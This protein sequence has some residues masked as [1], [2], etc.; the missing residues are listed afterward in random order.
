[1]PA[2]GVLGND[3]DPEGAGPDRERRQPAAH[4]TLSL[5]ANGGYT[6]TPTAN[7]S[8]ADSFTYRANSGSTPSN[9]ATVSLT[10]NAVNDPPVAG[11]DSGTTNEETA[12]VVAAPGV[13]GNDTDVDGATLTASVVVQPAHGTL[14]LNANGSYTLH[15]DGELQRRGQLHLPGQRRLGALQHGDRHPHRRARQRPPVAVADT[16]TTNEDTVLNGATVLG[17][18]TDPDAGTALTAVVDSCRRVARCSSTRTAPSP[19]RRSSTTAA[20]SPSAT[21]P[22]TGRSHRP[23]S[24]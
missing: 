21:T 6:Y 15:A 18:D 23:R 7:Y 8:G 11:D 5:S 24:R 16:R 2:P 12:L 10:I 14:S 9:T 17:N 13:L 22:A 1:M 19:T 20:R 4:G 3:S